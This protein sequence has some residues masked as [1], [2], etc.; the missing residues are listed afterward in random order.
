[1]ENSKKKKVFSSLKSLSNASSLAGAV[2]STAS[3]VS[4]SLQKSDAKKPVE[5]PN[6]SNN[7]QD[8]PKTRIQIE[9]EKRNTKQRNINR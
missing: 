3:T 2:S 7:F 5:Q 4:S 6:S 8:K 1:M 9:K